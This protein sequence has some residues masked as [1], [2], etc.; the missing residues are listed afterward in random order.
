MAD[1]TQLD[2]GVWDH[3]R[4]EHDVFEVRRGG[5]LMVSVMFHHPRLPSSTIVAQ[6][7]RLLARLTKGTVALESQVLPWRPAATSTSPQPTWPAL[8]WKSRREHDEELARL[9]RLQA[10]WDR[11]RQAAAL[12][13]HVTE[14]R[15]ALGIPDR[16]PYTRAQ[17]VALARIIDAAPRVVH[18]ESERQGSGR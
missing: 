12:D 3:R 14:Q 18:R 11:S 2:A 13:R 10:R 7:V 9:T 8:G 1:L 4:R 15:A 16:P 17:L 6:L 5:V